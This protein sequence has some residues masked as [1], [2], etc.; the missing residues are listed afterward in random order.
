MWNKDLLIYAKVTKTI[1][2]NV[3]I[4]RMIVLSVLIHFGNAKEIVLLNAPPIFIKINRYH[5]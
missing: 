2:F 1:V 3:T 4:I 5:Q